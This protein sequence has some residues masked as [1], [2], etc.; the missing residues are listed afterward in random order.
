MKILHVCQSAY[1]GVTHQAVILSKELM[2]QGVPVEAACSPGPLANESRHA[3]IR[4]FTLP[5]VRPVSPYGDLSA[6][7]ALWRILR[8]GG[9]SLV[10]TRRKSESR[11]PPRRNPYRLHITR[12]VLS[13]CGGRVRGKVLRRRQADRKRM[14]EATLGV[15][16][17][18][19]LHQNYKRLQGMIFCSELNY[20]I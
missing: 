16:A 10:Y 18:V 15:Y 5:L 8:K 11:R 2:D 4:V 9:Y 12:L 19:A 6:A 1:G 14:I 17:E 7:Y 20:Y 3:G 13:G